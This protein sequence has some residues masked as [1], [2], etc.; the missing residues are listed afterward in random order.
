V[1]FWN[2]GEHAAKLDLLVC[3]NVLLVLRAEV[4]GKYYSP[5]GHRDG[6]YVFDLEDFTQKHFLEGDYHSIAKASDGSGTVLAARGRYIDVLVLE[7][8]RLSRTSYFHRQHRPIERNR[9]RDILLL[10][11]SLAYVHHGRNNTIEVYNILTG[12]LVRAFD[13]SAAVTW[14]STNGRELFL[15]VSAERHGGDYGP[16]I[17]A[18]L[19]RPY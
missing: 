9:A 10:F 17:R 12:E 2:E 5:T 15:G 19:L 16:T 4:F 8:G 7:D 13:P 6:I 14:A 11:Q 1:V 18:F 3:D